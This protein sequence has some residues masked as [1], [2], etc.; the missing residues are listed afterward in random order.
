MPDHTH[1]QQIGRIGGLVS[2]ATR[3]PEQEANL[4]AKG[5]AGRMRRFLEQVPAEITDDAERQRRARQLQRA[6]MQAIALKSAARRR[7]AAV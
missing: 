3:T 7:K 4:K 2:A 6:H 1:Y 5:A